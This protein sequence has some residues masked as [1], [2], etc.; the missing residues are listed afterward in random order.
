MAAF[1][2]AGHA[3][4]LAF[5]VTNDILTQVETVC[6]FVGMA[7]ESDLFETLEL[8]EALPDAPFSELH[9]RR[10]DVPIE[11]VWQSA[12]DVTANEVRTLMPLFV[13]RGLPT[14]LM[15]KRPALPTGEQPLLDL[16]INEG[17][18]LLRK[19]PHPVDGRAALL[20]GAVGKFWAVAH[21]QPTV[22]DNAEDFLAFD[23]P[24]YAKTVCRVEAIAEGGYTRLETQTVIAGTDKASNKKFK[25]YWMLIRGPSGLIRRS[26]L[27]AIDRRAQR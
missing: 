10:I 13:L 4:I 12:L 3:L 8:G 24:D 15:G 7:T 18:V 27:A 26:W 11:V 6:Q 14:R 20:F 21:N 22:F 5:G 17:F 25:P 9:H 23:E 2:Q 19:D 1:A 16:F